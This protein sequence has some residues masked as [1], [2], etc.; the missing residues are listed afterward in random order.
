VQLLTITNFPFPLG[1]DNK[2]IEVDEE[3]TTKFKGELEGQ[4]CKTVE[5]LDVVPFAHE[6]P[7][8]KWTLRVCCCFTFG[9][10]VFLW[11]YYK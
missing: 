11:V 2:T 5:Y 4:E 1:I 7:C 6:T 3:K 10:L 8:Q 9:V